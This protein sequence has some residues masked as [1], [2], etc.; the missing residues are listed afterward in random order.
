MTRILEKS[1]AIVIACAAARQAGAAEHPPVQALAQLSESFQALVEQV[2]PSVVQVVVTGYAATDRGANQPDVVM[3]RQRSIGSGVVVDASGYI[4]TNAHVVRG[5]RRVQVIVPRDR[6][7]ASGESVWSR[8]AESDRTVDA[9]IVGTTRELDLALLKIDAAAELR[10]LPFAD[11]D[12][13]RQGELVF[14]F[15]SPEGLGDSV[16]MGLV[17]ATARQPD[18]DTPIVYIQ[19]DAAINHGS[20][21]GPLVNTLGE[22]VGI[23]T[24]IVSQSGG[25][26]G[27][28]FAIPS[29]LVQMAYRK[30]RDSGRLRRGEVGMMVQTIT[31][32]LAA[33]LH[34][35]RQRGLIVADVAPGKPAAA[36]GLEIGDVIDAVDGQPIDNVLPFAV[37][38]FVSD[39]DERMQ[40]SG[41]R[42][43]RPF[44]V[45]LA[46]VPRR[47]DPDLLTDLVDPDSC[48][49]ASLGIV[50]LALT[51]DV[52]DLLPDLRASYGVVVAARAASSST[53][54]AALTTGDVI[55]SVNGAAVST[56]DELRT[57]LKSTP[58]ASPVVLQIERNGQL[59]FLTVEL[60]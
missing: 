24:F 59:S 23:N 20:S 47:T 43:D 4:V 6:T 14:A 8:V 54:D 40:L 55:H 18:A 60:E 57:Q 26:E 16:S 28:G 30:L 50:G 49:I 27:L 1:L 11:Y 9:R 42:G 41:V 29:A 10:P 7:A 56:L 52:A 19:T 36:A 45:D 15:G 51:A 48:T 17:S 2:S 12:K 3:S 35:A 21:G 44:T 39:G 32:A 46:V 38:M 22:L 53:A 37:R 31:P 34:L 33:G 13:L 5:A 58:R 25:N